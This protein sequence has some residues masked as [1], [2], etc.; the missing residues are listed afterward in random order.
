MNQPVEYRPVVGNVL[1]ELGTAS[2]TARELID[3][4]TALEGA[5]QAIG[6]YAGLIAVEET[7]A[8]PDL[9]AIAGWRADQEAMAARRRALT[10]QDADE[11]E[12]IRDDVSD[13]LAQGDDDDD[14]EDDADEDDA[15]EDD[16]DEDDAGPDDDADDDLD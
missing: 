2:G 10:P 1:G 7:G 8:E 12:S 9:E 15:D 16:A 13:L 3:Y 11:I 4:E 6:Y 5:A 14:D